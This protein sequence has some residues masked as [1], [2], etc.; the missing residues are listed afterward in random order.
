LIFGDVPASGVYWNKE[1][2]SLIRIKFAS[3]LSDYELAEDYNLKQH[4]AE[5]VPGN[6][7]FV[8]FSNVFLG[9]IDGRC[10]LFKKLS[11]VLGIEWHS[12]TMK[13]FCE[14]PRVFN[15]A[16]PLDVADLDLQACVKTMNIGTA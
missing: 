9:L 11:A 8:C 4:F 12:A 13:A 15:F 5:A 10:L 1:L 16:E 3:A 7:Y 6:V 2:K 14:N